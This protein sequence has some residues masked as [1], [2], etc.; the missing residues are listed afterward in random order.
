MAVEIDISKKVFTKSELIRFNISKHYLVL[1][2]LLKII[3]Q[4]E[5]ILAICGK[6]SFDNNFVAQETISLLVA[7]KITFLNVHLPVVTHLQF[8]RCN[9]CKII[10]I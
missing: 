5:I 1:T 6:E 10:R 2:V 8:I 7:L 4:I 9:K 3:V